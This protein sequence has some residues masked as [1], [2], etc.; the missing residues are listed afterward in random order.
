MSGPPVFFVVALAAIF[1]DKSC[2]W[3]RSGLLISFITFV[4]WLIFVIGRDV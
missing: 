2:R 3:A 1:M 4:L